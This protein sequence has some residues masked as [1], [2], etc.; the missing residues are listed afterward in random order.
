MAGVSDRENKHVARQWIE[1]LRLNTVLDL[2]AGVGTYSIM[3][4]KPGQHWTALEVF[5]PYVEMFNLWGKY[6][7]VIVADARKAVYEDY[8]LIIAADM[9]EHMQKDE[10]KELLK[11]LFAHA[12]HVLICFPVI[13]HDQHAGA[14]GNDYETH[15]DHWTDEEMV[16]FLEGREICNRVVGEVSAYYMVRGD[17]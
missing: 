15:I 8:D 16:S 9:L 1:D 17:L 3:C 13:H 6:D 4:W 12:R 11:T 2:G 14:E 7:H 5:E 10:A